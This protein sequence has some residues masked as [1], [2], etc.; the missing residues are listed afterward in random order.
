MDT[1]ICSL[2]RCEATSSP[3]RAFHPPPAGHEVRERRG[4][5]HTQ[6]GGVGHPPALDPCPGPNVFFPA[7][8]EPVSQEQALALLRERVR[9]R[10]A[11][12]LVMNALVGVGVG[13]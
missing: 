13:R 1:F 6:R 10:Q 12:G 7:N 2:I 3:I 5:T 4:H 9:V 8:R 11:R